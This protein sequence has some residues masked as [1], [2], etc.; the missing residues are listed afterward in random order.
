MATIIMWF[1]L[2]NAAKGHFNYQVLALLE[3]RETYCL[4]TNQIDCTT[5]CLIEL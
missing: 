5:C 2:V 1:L 3:K 4:F